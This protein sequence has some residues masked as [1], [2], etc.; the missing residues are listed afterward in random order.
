MI[1]FA[2]NVSNLPGPQDNP[3]NIWR[4]VST[5]NSSPFARL[6]LV[7]LVSSPMS[8]PWLQEP[9]P[10]GP[11][12]WKSFGADSP[13]IWPYMDWT[14]TEWGKSSTL[15]GYRQTSFYCTL[16]YCTSQILCFVQIEGLWQPYAEQVYQCHFSKSICSLCLYYI[17]V[18]LAIFQTFLLL[19][20]L[21]WPVISNL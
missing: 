19:Y 14:T 18:I 12:P 4:Q 5:S 21:W 1:K 10:S 3:L 6:C 7:L 13:Q 15:I 11:R 20:L 16:L 2:K 8:M 9:S 17:L